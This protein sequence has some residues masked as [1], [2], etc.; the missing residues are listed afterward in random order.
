M[1]RTVT[2]ESSKS[3]I[4]LRHVLLLAVVIE[5]TVDL[6]DRLVL[7]PGRIEGSGTSDIHETGLLMLWIDTFNMLGHVS[8]SLCCFSR[9]P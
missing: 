9:S 3:M 4:K 6:L 5:F 1:M 7:T 2:V 8:L